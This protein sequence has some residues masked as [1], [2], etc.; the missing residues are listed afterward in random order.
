M[1]ILFLTPTLPYPPDMGGKIVVF[2]TLR[3]LYPKHEL[4]L[5]SFIQSG[6]ERYIENLRLYCKS[7]QV[8]PISIEFRFSQLISNLFLRL[9]YTIH[10]YSS[11]EMEAKFRQLIETVKPDLVQVEHLHLFQYV[12]N[13]W[14]PPAVLREHNVES[15]L[16]KRYSESAR[17]PFAR[18]YAR[19]QYR[20]LLNYENRAIKY[21]SLCLTLT[22]DDRKELRRISSSNKIEVLPPGVDFDYFRP[23]PTKRDNNAILFL[24]NLIYK[25]T[26]EA[27][28]FFLKRI[29][30]LV[31]EKRPHLRLVQIGRCP[32]AILEKIKN[33]KN[34][35]V[36]GLVKDI[37]PIV[38]SCSLLVVP[39]TIGSGIRIKILEAMAMKLPVVSTSVGCE[40]IG[41]TDQE[42]CLLADEPEDFANKIGL[43]I[44]DQRLAEQIANRAHDFVRSN[45]DWDKIID[46]LNNIYQMITGSL[47]GAL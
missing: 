33:T 10:K 14:S 36:C 24:G 11:S 27:L 20:K 37:R 26:Q 47:N 46:K 34:L 2:N 15:L 31:L 1:K 17:N 42:D 32:I 7:I 19:I 44:D 38:S 45:Y 18:A 4:H 9:P 22:E 39:F 3:R 13:K 6:Q 16:M 41:L 30:P 43:L 29:W 35:E 28:F 8:V 21:A 12:H 5:L 25:P 40:G 23:L